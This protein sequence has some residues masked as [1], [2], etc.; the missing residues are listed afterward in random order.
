MGVI[1]WFEIPVSDIERAVSFYNQI[2]GVEMQLSDLTETQGTMVAIFPH[3][4]GAGGMLVEGEQQGYIP[5]HEGSLV[6]LDLDG[7][8]E[9]TL[10]K[11]EPAGGKIL[12]PKTSLGEYGWTA[13]IEDTE[14]NRIGLRTEE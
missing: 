6:Y 13:W 2:L 14:G 7:A 3:H 1:Y 10:K 4:G 11:I 9:D 12:L 5:S 8:L